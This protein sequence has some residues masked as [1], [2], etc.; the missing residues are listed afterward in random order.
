MAFVKVY[1]NGELKD[2]VAIDKPVILVGR[3]TDSDVRIDN[4]GV[5]AHHAR[6]LTDSEGFQIEDAGSKNGVFVNGERVSRRP[7]KFGDE[8][9]V[10]RHTLKVEA[11]SSRRNVSA[12]KVSDERQVDQGATVEM[13]IS[14]LADLMK[15][16]RLLRDAYL[17][18]I[19]TGEGRA[20]Y[21]LARASFKIGK[22][23]DSD[24]RV[25]GWLAPRVAARIVRKEDG[26]YLI[27][28]KRGKVRINGARVFMARRLRDG[29]RLG[30]RGLSMHFHH[31]TAAA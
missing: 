18:L 15:D 1:F 31:K 19:G 30:V 25:S 9:A 17:L 4:A 26:F 5:S 23:D 27:P 20:K 3:A 10:F 16:R 24:M 11:L 6:L 12:S 7:V 21:P 28:E 14:R 22:S 13:D 8:I 2:E 29:D